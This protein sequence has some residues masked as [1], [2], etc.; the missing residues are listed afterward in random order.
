MGREPRKVRR[1]PGLFKGRSREESTV[2][3]LG[4]ELFHGFFHASFPY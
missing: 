4:L 3:P 2:R 1:V